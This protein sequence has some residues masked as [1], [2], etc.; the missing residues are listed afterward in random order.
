[1]RDAPLLARKLGY[2]AGGE[3]EEVYRTFW[4]ADSSNCSRLPDEADLDQTSL[5]DVKNWHTAQPIALE[6]ACP[7]SPSRAV[8]ADQYQRPP[9]PAPTAQQTAEARQRP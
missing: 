7:S 4:T 9:A 1:M 2:T 5:Y 3:F 6:H 8:A